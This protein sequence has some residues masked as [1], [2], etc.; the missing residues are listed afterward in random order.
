MR[1]FNFSDAIEDSVVF[2]HT[3]EMGKLEATRGEPVPLD[4]SPDEIESKIQEMLTSIPPFLEAKLA[5][6]KK[7]AKGQKEKGLFED[8]REA[9]IR[10]QFR[11]PPPASIRHWLRDN[12][13]ES[14][15]IATPGFD[16]TEILLK[17]WPTLAPSAPFVIFSEY[18]EPLV[19]VT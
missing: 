5:G 1:N 15:I 4:E 8:K 14:L 13:S 16:A 12:I 2:F 10:R 17:L 7:D 3:S 18:S 11:K 9:R 19:Q 6:F